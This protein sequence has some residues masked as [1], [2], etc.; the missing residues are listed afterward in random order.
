MFM[1]QGEMFNRSQQ[2]T[3]GCFESKMLMCVCV[4]LRADVDMNLGGDEE[5]TSFYKTEG[6]DSPQ[7]IFPFFLFFSIV[8]EASSFCCSRILC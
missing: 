4:C 6:F 7:K 8:L 2:S 3:V 1:S 5:G